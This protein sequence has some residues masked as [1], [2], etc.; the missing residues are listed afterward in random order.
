MK[1]HG[2]LKT[3]CIKKNSSGQTRRVTFL[4]LSFLVFPQGSL[5][6]D[7]LRPWEKKLVWESL[8]CSP[9]FF[10]LHMRKLRLRVERSI[11]SLIKGSRGRRTFSLLI[12][13]PDHQ[14]QMSSMSSYQRK[15]TPSFLHRLP[16]SLKGYK[17]NQGKNGHLTLSEPR[18]YP[19]VN[20]LSTA[21]SAH[22]R[23]VC[24][25]DKGSTSSVH[26]F[27]CCGHSWS[28]LHLYISTCHSLSRSLAPVQF[29]GPVL[30][31]LPLHHQSIR[32]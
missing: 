24:G 10:V 6:Q 7:A 27:F 28:S 1:C 26:S 4:L 3:Q 11:L 18:R 23:P 21:V 14:Y 2:Q 8:I 30:E 12:P 32:Y 15:T 13:S 31:C 16:L 9:K 29:L 17:L 22:S 19:Q 25:R 5:P 20:K